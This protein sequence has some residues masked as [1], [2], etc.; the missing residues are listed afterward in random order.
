MWHYLH[1]WVSPKWFYYRSG[2]WLPWLSVMTLL[3]LAVGTIW[4]LVIAPPDYQQHD[5]MRIMYVHV[6]A[7]ILSES[8]FLLMALC[9][10]IFL[11]WRIKL[12]DMLAS[13]MAPFGASMAFL[14]LFTGA[15]WGIPTWGTWWTWDAR[16]TSMLILLFLYFGVI[17]LRGAFQH[18][19]AGARAAGIIA[20]VG[21]VNLPVIKY[22]VVWWNTLHQ[23]SSFSITHKPAMPASMWLPLLVMVLGSYLFMA[24]LIMMR[25][26]S[27]ILRREAAMAWVKTLVTHAMSKEGASS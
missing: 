3:T 16:L 18:T 15:V 4:G 12:A 5:S 7:A 14:A 19:L 20:L 27:E 1:Q 8:V 10:G 21:L 25:T 23:A 24:T 22:S 9:S 26:R 2:R 11:I 6:P 17:A 13:V